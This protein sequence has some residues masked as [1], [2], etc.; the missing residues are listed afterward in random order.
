MPDSLDSSNVVGMP[1]QIAI[2]CIKAVVKGK[3]QHHLFRHNACENA[4]MTRASGKP[5]PGCWLDCW[6]YAVSCSGVSGIVKSDPANSSTRYA[7]HRRSANAFSSTWRPRAPHPLITRFFRRRSALNTTSVDLGRARHESLRQSPTGP[8]CHRLT[9]TMNRTQARH[10][11]PPDRDGRAGAPTL[12]TRSCVPQGLREDDL[13]REAGGV[14]TGIA[15]RLG[16]RST[17]RGTHLRLPC[18]RV[19]CHRHNLAKRGR[20]C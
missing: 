16:N 7:C 19:C 2:S 1:Y 4:T 20:C 15:A 11:E 6:G 3:A 9:A 13:L 8:L 14:P 10:K 17:K 18:Q 12:L 5:H